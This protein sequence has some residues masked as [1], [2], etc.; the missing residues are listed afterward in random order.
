MVNN[1]PLPAWVMAEDVNL[2]I[3]TWWWVYIKNIILLFHQRHSDYLVINLSLSFSLQFYCT[4]ILLMGINQ[5]NCLIRPGY[6]QC[7]RSP[8]WSHSR[9][10]TGK[11]GIHVS[12][13]AKP[14]FLSR[15][16]NYNISS[17]V[18]TPYQCHGVAMV[19]A[20]RERGILRCC[21]Q[22]LKGSMTDIS[23]WYTKAATQ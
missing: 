1:Y 20:P 7:C 19:A 5:G 10:L 15:K 4:Y 18:R 2:V 8:L 3:F 11:T 17:A 16:P 13:P 9:A 22:S 21:H 6:N 14:K 23:A 12:G